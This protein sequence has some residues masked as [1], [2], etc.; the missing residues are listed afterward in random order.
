MMMVLLDEPTLILFA[1]PD[2]P[3]DRLEAVD[4]IS[5][6]YSFCDDDGQRH[7]G[8]VT[9]TV[10]RSFPTEYLPRAEGERDATIAMDSADRAVILEPNLWHVDLESLRRHLKSRRSV[11]T[12]R[13]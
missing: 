1:S 10:G 5:G 7:V 4:A 9:R 8:V 2:K 6:G 3:P 13:L 12:R 11:G